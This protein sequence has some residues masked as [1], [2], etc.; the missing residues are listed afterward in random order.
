MLS[1]HGPIRGNTNRI[2]IEL[3]LQPGDS[4]GHLDQ[5]VFSCPEVAALQFSAKHYFSRNSNKPQ[6]V[7]TTTRPKCAKVLAEAIANGRIDMMTWFDIK[8]SA[9]TMNHERKTSGMTVEEMVEKVRALIATNGYQFT[10]PT[11][12]NSGELAFK[13]SDNQHLSYDGASNTWKP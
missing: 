8:R 4:A 10:G 7:V 1:D 5:S 2:W 11:L 6:S 13:T 3:G 12:E 9:I